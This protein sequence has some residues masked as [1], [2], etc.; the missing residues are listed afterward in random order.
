MLLK[1]KSFLLSTTLLLSAVAESSAWTLKSTAS[2]SSFFDSFSFFTSSDPTHGFVQYVD[3]N[4]ATSSGLIYTQNGQV[5]IKADNTSVT[6]NGRPSVRIV[7][8]AS[9]SSGL[10]ILDLAHMPT[11]CGTWPAYWLVGPDWPNNGEI[12]VN[13]YNCYILNKLTICK[14]RLS[15]A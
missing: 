2:G 14:Y 10:F 11:G 13:I 5:I 15:K 4:T 9:Y 7:S 6:P 8:Q 12:D 1:A 3:K